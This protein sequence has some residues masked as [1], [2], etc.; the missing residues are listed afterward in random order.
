MRATWI[1]ARRELFSFFVSPIAYVVLTTWMLINGFSFYMLVSWYAAN[2]S[3]G[4]SD[5]PLAHFFGQTILFYLP[6]LF[7]GPLLTMRLM[8][9]ERSKGTI[10]PLLTSPAPDAAIVFGKYLAGLLIWCSMWLPTLLFVF[11]TSQFGSVDL[12][13]VAA[14]YVGVLNIGVYYIAIGLLMSTVSKNQLVAAMLSFMVLGMLFLVGM[15]RFVVADGGEIF[16]Y[17]SIWDHMGTASKGVIDTRSLV[18]GISIAGMALFL[19]ARAVARLRS[20]GQRGEMTHNLLGSV[21][22]LVIVCMLNYL[23]YRH[24]ARV[25]WT[26]S[27]R[28]SLSERTE[29]V[30]Q[31]LDEPIDVHLFLSPSEQ[32][33]EDVVELLRSYRAESTQVTINEVDPHRDPSGYRMLLERYGV[34][35]ATL[36]SGEQVTD[37]AAVVAAGE[38]SW[39]ITRDDLVSYDYGSEPDAMPQVSVQA[40]RAFTGAIVEATT[41]EPTRLCVTEG[42]GEWSLGSEPGRSLRSLEDELQRDNV[43]MQSFRTLGAASVPE[44]CDAVLVVGP[45]N[46]F[47]EAEADV[48]SAYLREGG[49]LFVAIDPILDGSRIRPSGLEEVVRLAGIRIEPSL[50]LEGSAELRVAGSP[51]PV[52]PYAVINYGEHPTT[53]RL[54][55]AS[56]T[57]LIEARG[58]SLLSDGGATAVAS[59]SPESFGRREGLVPEMPA[60]ATGLDDRGPIVI[61]AAGELAPGEANR[62]DDS[63]GRAFVIGDSDFL[64][65][66]LLANPALVNF[67]LMN[68]AIGWL[69]DRDALIA[70]AP[71]NESAAAI[72][73]S[74][75][76]VEAVAL[77]VIV[78]I[79]LAFLVLG[80]AIGRTRRS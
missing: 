17:V 13:A 52:G 62:A 76:D 63:V 53:A 59:A 61:A 7:F 73:M 38:Q 50:V 56:P 66:E 40:E 28:Y 71:R 37:I 54:A 11:I 72:M 77:R 49:K 70:I 10:E 43:E 27:Q 44:G 9:E 4:G 3:T 12:G 32:S 58:L 51:S 74:E 22:M 45:S 26:E 18:Y 30:L 57:V 20:G 39:R 19:T 68:A 79:P 6:A 47:S 67:Q 55:P 64:Q 5:T 80:L 33:F 35:A 78:L 60:E 34:R 69:S 36:S 16:E 14:S 15:L 46:A 41:G 21:L 24:Y 48:L 31:E 25:D 75:E 65:A 2:A 8:A 29:Q 23:A 42:H 1:I